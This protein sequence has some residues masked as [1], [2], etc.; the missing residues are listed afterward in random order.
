MKMKYP[1]ILNMA[2][3]KIFF[4][5]LLLLFSFGVHVFAQADTEPVPTAD[6]PK[7]YSPYPSPSGGYVTDIAGIITDA[8]KKYLNVMI[9][10]TEKKTGFEMAVVTINSIRDYP[11]GG[12]TIEEFATGLFNKY[13][14]GNLPENKGV[15]LL[16][17]REDRKARIE[18]G[19]GY[20][21]SRDADAAGIMDGII[22]PRFKKDKFSR[23]ITEGS[24]AIAR[25]FGG[26]RW[27]FARSLVIIPV[28]IILLITVAIS[29]FKNGKKGWGWVVV[30]LIFI[31]L[32]IL[33]KIISRIF[34][35]IGESMR[36]GGGIGGFGGGFGGGFSG[37]GGATGSW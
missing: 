30:G 14:I 21:R 37:G 12:N 13:G 19:A 24:K 17:A 16:V 4:S 7:D 1:T 5:T 20:G 29:L 18:L 31:L 15:L 25:E 22:I 34:R 35:G 28:L 10:Q 2:K 9:Y 26:V 23:G 36:E 6:T 8:D 3:N 33:L 32:I 11:G 27:T